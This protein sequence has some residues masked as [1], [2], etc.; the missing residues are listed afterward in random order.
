M[1]AEIWNDNAELQPQ[2]KG[3]PKAPVLSHVPAQ[4]S[5][6][7]LRFSLFKYLAVI[8]SPVLR[9][10]NSADLADFSKSMGATL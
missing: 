6:H 10:E 5:F 1:P 9:T 2:A 7:L 4:L 8:C 3:A